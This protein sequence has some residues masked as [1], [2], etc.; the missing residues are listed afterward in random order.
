MNK[1]PGNM[2]QNLLPSLF[3]YIPAIFSISQKP[4]YWKKKQ[5][6]LYRWSIASNSLSENAVYFSPYRTW[7]FVHNFN[8]KQNIVANFSKELPCIVQNVSISYQV[9]KAYELHSTGTL[10]QNGWLY[11]VVSLL[12]CHALPSHVVMSSHLKQIISYF[13]ANS[14][15]L[16]LLFSKLRRNVI[17]RLVGEALYFT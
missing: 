5:Y 7:Y 16:S 12:K 13:V 14:V 4:L 17:S 9:L 1:L 10:T 6:S 3:L 8:D 2:L 15:I 11:D